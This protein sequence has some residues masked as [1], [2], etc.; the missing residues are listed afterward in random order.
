MAHWFSSSFL[1]PKQNKT[2]ARE[3]PTS[4]SNFNS[5][6]DY[7]PRFKVKYKYTQSE[8]TENMATTYFKTLIPRGRVESQRQR[9]TCLNVHCEFISKA[10]QKRILATLSQSLKTFYDK[11]VK[12]GS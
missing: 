7:L 1:K 3:K 4:P 10:G 2:T 12:S 9:M 6:S 11:K 5:T 8:L